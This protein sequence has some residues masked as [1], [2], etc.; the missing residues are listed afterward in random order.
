MTQAKT[1]DTVQIHYSGKLKDGTQFDSS[2]GRDPLEF[3]I[4]ENKI[5]PK[6]EAA[7]IGMTVGDTATAE[8]AAEDA[9]GP[10]RPEGIQTV[11]RSVIPADVD[12]TVG[13]QLQATAQNGQVIVL[14]VVEANDQTVTLDSNHPLAGEDLV[15][16]VELVEIVASAA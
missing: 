14:T 3:V 5:L 12:V 11:E 6:L 10:R 7:V 1:G 13:N 9:Y 8:I 2:E 4:G 15:F 16:E